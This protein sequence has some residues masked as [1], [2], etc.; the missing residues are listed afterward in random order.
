MAWFWGNGAAFLPSE[1]VLA[2]D[3]IVQS[4][5]DTKYD[6]TS[7]IQLIAFESQTCYFYFYVP[8]NIFWCVFSSVC[9]NC[10]W[11]SPRQAWLIRAA[12]LLWFRLCGSCSDI[13]TS[14]KPHI[15]SIH[16]CSGVG[17][18]PRPESRAWGVSQQHWNNI[19]SEET[20]SQTVIHPPPPRE[21]H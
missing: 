4:P 6:S 16:K 5:L 19:N 7:Q 1:R 17:T 3:V 15:L 10:R 9:N 8:W 11:K 21:C 14:K 20:T 18:S 12:L 2:R 13:Q